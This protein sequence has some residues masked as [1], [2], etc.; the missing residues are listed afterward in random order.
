MFK[1]REMS[2]FLGRKST[3]LTFLQISSFIF[4]NLYMMA[5]IKKW[6]K[7]NILIFMENSYY[8][9]FLDLKSRFLKFSK[10]LLFKFFLNYTW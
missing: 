9:T 8:R 1:L 10:N 6:F 7:V 4:L 2:R 3:F 5:G